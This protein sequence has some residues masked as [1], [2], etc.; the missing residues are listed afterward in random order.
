MN[1]K[2]LL[3]VGFL[4]VALGFL[5]CSATKSGSDDDDATTHT[6]TTTTHSTTTTTSTGLGAMG[7]TGG[8]TGGTISTGGAGGGGGSGGQASGDC[9]DQVSSITGECD[10]FKQDCAPGKMCA[11]T[12]SG[13]G[14][15]TPAAASCVTAQNGLKDRGMS[16]QGDTECMN[17]MLCISNRCSPY[18]CPTTG[19]PC[20]TGTCDVHLT[21]ND[22][23]ATWAMVC[24]YDISCQLFEHQCQTPAECHLS[25]ADQGISVCDAPSASH[26]AEGEV[27]TYR[28][29]CG[30]DEMCNRNGADL[31]NGGTTGKCR[32]LCK[33]DTWQSLMVGNGGCVAG[34][35]CNNMGI[36]A[37]PN[38]GVCM[39]P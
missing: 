2:S 15:A 22:N 30:D 10:L 14:G 6:T 9:P 36:A 19:A 17:G 13:S 8:G 7:G 27:C 21:F 5:A 18:C 32:Y 38:L 28:N 35:P 39:L 23:D 33:V 20:G 25:Q 4:S 34:Q 29:D 12:S 3:G 16:C 1:V 26:V 11:V 37:L 24:G 31:G